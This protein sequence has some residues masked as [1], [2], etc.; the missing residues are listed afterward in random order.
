MGASLTGVRLAAEGDLAAI[1]T[2][3]T[4]SRHRLASWEP[5]YWRV[6]E[7]ADA[8]HPLWLAHLVKSEDVVTRVVA[9]GNDVIGFAASNPQPGQYFVDDIAVADDGD[10]STAG[11]AL[12]EAI[13]ERPAVTAVPR[14]D[15][16]RQQA[17]VRAGLDAVSSFRALDLSTLGV[18]LGR[19]TAVPAP[20]PEA[21]APAPASAIVIADDARVFIGDG[22]GG[23]AVGSLPFPA[24]PIYDP[25]GPV[26]VIDRVVG[27][28][29]SGLLLQML[30][31]AL[32]R[33]DAGALVV[34]DRAD[35][36][37]AAIADGLGARYPVDIY[38]WP[39]RVE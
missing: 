13:A 24:P 32:E 37:L 3:A 12:F 9:R 16:A 18:R 35:P 28:D 19:Q 29:R 26:C 23:Y 5:W 11:V 10:W 6:S 15:T 25:G 7:H 31:L 2:L 4:R 30:S 20:R 39:D 36:E 38:R 14:A 1:S 22:R 17:A 27:N 34:V 21:L 8:L 33:G